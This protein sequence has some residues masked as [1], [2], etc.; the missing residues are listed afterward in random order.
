M[1]STVKEILP[2][3]SKRQIGGGNESE[4]TELES[5]FSEMNKCFW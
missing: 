4:K 1:Q 3:Q 5:E 2:L